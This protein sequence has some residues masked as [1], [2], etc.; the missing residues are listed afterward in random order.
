M[1]QSVNPGTWSYFDDGCNLLPHHRALPG[2]PPHLRRKQL[3]VRLQ[4]TFS[5]QGPL[6]W[7]SVSSPQSPGRDRAP[8]QGR[9]CEGCRCFWD[10]EHHCRKK[11][12]KKT[13]RRRKFICEKI[14]NLLRTDALSAEFSQTQK[15]GTFSPLTSSPPSCPEPAAPPAGCSAARRWSLCR[16]RAGPSG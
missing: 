3:S 1:N 8:R 11:N 16:R 13:Q 4:N 10:T 9:R 14:V 15:E 6:Y 2:E 5:W 12:T 7:F